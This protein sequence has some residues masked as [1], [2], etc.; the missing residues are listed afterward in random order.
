MDDADHGFRAFYN[1]Q[2]TLRRFGFLLCGSWSEG[3]ELA[4]PARRTRRA[5]RAGP[6]GCAAAW[7][8]AC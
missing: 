6:G 4:G 2:Y 7:S 5:W 3:D 1:N 8:P